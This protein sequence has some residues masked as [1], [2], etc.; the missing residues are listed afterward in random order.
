MTRS[1]TTLS[2]QGTQLLI[3]RLSKAARSLCRFLDDLLLNPEKSEVVAVGTP[4]QIRFATKDFKIN[5]AGSSLHLVDNVKSLGVYT[6][7]NLSMDVQVSAVCRSCNFHIRAFRPIRPDLLA[8][9]AKIF[10]CRIVGSRLDYCN[11]LLYGISAKNLKT[12]QRV[13]NNL[14]RITLM[15]PRRSSAEP[16]LRSLHWLPV[17]Q[18]IKYK[19]AMLTDSSANDRT[20][21]VFF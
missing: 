16:L 3:S 1:S 11:S 7:S 19:I 14:P 15:T 21:T 10:S 4:A 17:V 12:L 5:V 8:D 18:H 6:D 13:Q 2:A 9:L 20:A